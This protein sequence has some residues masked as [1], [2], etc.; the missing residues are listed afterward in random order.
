M[1]IQPRQ[2]TTKAE[3]DRFTGDAWFDL[4]VRG[5]PPSRVRASIVRFAPG[6]RNAWHRHPVGQVIHVTDGIGRMQARGGEL[7]EIQAGDTVVTPPGEW[8]WHGAAPDR[9]MTHF[10]V[11]ETDENGAETEWG[12]H[13]SD[14]EYRA[15]PGPRR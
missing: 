6:A 3:P 2:P 9:F 12:D 14:A 11:Y 4:V 5:E 15:N 8:H 1:Q 10:T 13:V 7:L